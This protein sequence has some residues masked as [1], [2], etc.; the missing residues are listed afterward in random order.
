MSLTGEALYWH[1]TLEA[2]VQDTW[3]LLSSALLE[4]FPRD[5][6]SSASTPPIPPT[7]ERGRIRVVD[8]TSPSFVGYVSNNLHRQHGWY[9]VAPG[10]ENALVVSCYPD[11]E[12]PFKIDAVNGNNSTKISLGIKCDAGDRSNWKV[13]RGSIGHAFIV[14]SDSREE[15]VENPCTIWIASASDGDTFDLTAMWKLPDG[16]LYALESAYYIGDGRIYVVPD[17][18]AFCAYHGPN[19]STHKAARLVFEPV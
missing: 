15:T 10:V 8:L 16:G 14:P 5:R 18:K 13:N 1:A 19:G 17:R 3:K 2:E 7:E 11:F 9:C 6:S 4:R 12:N